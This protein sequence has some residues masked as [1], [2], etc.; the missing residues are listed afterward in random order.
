MLLCSIFCAPDDPGLSWDELLQVGTRLGLQQ[1][2]LSDAMGT[3]D[4]VSAAGRFLP[5]KLRVDIDLLWWTQPDDLRSLDCFDFVYREF[6]Q[7]ARAIGKG[8]TRIPMET[9]IARAQ[10]EALDEHGVRVAIGALTLG[11][12][13]KNDDGILIPLR[14]EEFREDRLPSTMLR[15]NTTNGW[16]ST[17]P[18]WS[19]DFLSILEVTRD[20]IERR[21]EGRPKWSE[22]IDEFG[23]KLE[24]LG[25]GEYRIWW[26]QMA[27]E[28]RHLNP[29]ETPTAA[30]VLAAALAEASLVFVCQVARSRGLALV[31]DNVFEKGPKEWSFDGLT[32][33]AKRS[34]NP[35]FNDETGRRAERL[36]RLR[37]RIHAG[38][39]LA[40]QATGSALDLRPEEARESRESLDT[41]LRA[42]LDWLDNTPSATTAPNT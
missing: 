39:F 41:I 4:S 27:A 7:A 35:I 13:L 8:R 15:Q 34:T 18:K 24:T 30:V 2:E 36:N 3:F 1:G 16:S 38:R 25:H 21:Q 40:S 26:R 29:A 19:E 33:G 9:L 31:S 11:Q 22:P 37:Q 32:K 5:P 14:F 20:V 17:T 6:I 12:K 28:L 10:A 42:I 23:A